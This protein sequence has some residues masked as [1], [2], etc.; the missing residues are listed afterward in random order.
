MVQMLLYALLFI[1]LMSFEWIS[2]GDYIWAV[3]LLGLG[4]LLVGLAVFMPEGVP[5]G[6]HSM[7]DT[8]RVNVVDKY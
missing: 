4:C 1:T 2:A 6:I 3:A 8:H 5:D 7:W